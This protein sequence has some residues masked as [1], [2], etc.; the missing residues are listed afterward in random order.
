MI[1]AK[2]LVI[3]SRYEFAISVYLKCLQLAQVT[4]STIQNSKL[5]A[6]THNPDYKITDAVI[7]IF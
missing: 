1:Y 6:R 7:L 2:S 3:G 4:I 5:E